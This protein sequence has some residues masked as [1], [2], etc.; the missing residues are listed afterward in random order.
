[1]RHS[2]GKTQTLRNWA[3]SFLLLMGS[4]SLTSCDWLAHHFFNS[5]SFLAPAEIRSEPM[6][7]YLGVDGLSYPLV[8][9]ILVGK[10]SN[11]GLAGDST[12]REYQ[13]RLPWSLAAGVA[14]FPVSSDTSWTRIMRAK[15]LEGHEF[16]YYDPNRDEIVNGGVAGLLKHVIPTFADAISPEADYFHFFD[17]RANGYFHALHIYQNHFNSFGETLDQVFF[18][19]EGRMKSESVFT[20]YITEID[21]AGHMLQSSDAELM[22]RALFKRIEDFH[23]QHPERKVEFTLFSDHGMDFTPLPNDGLKRR[24]RL[25]DIFREQGIE[26]VENRNGRAV[27]RAVPFAIAVGHVRVGYEAAVTAPALV[28]EVA[29][30]TSRAAA[31][32]LVVG[33]LA[34]CG[35]GFEAE[36]TCF[37]I[38]AEGAE[39]LTFAFDRDSNQYRLRLGQTGDQIRER[40]DLGDHSVWNSLV[41]AEVGSVHD[42][43]ADAVFEATAWRKYPDFLHRIRSGLEAQHILYPPEILVSYRKGYVAKGFDLPINTDDVANFG[44]HGALHRDGSIGVVLSTEKVLPAVMRSENLLDAFPR[45]R[46]HRAEVR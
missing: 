18:L 46:E 11:G 34:F 5:L 28:P 43:A 12:V 44:F 21:T 14:M 16:A 30:R 40:L 37:G 26:V 33:K 29:R 4:A 45:I 2:L 19:I 10:T 23:F 15:P 8:Q 31:I 7:V 41:S 22:A 27:D 6:R 13:P 38:W 9:Q 35:A 42:L 25:A 20:A 17:F 3:L 39:L 24:V 36:A 1:M 32:D